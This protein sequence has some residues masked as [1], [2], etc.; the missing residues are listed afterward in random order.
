MNFEFFVYVDKP[1]L[2]DLRLDRSPAAFAPGGPVA[3]RL[4]ARPIYAIVGDTLFVHGGVLPAHVDQLER[5]DREARAWLAG[6]RPTADLPV[7]LS[8]P[9]SPVWTRRYGTPDADQAAV[10]ADADAVL[11]RL[12]LRRMVVAH[13]V[14]AGGVD[15]LCAGRVW[16][17]DTGL[18]HFYG[19]PLEILELRGDAA[20][21]LRAKLK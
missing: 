13:T 15:S 5:L 6:E 8:D 20:S 10:C 21:V 18:A 16:R 14:R 4:R 12:H 2:Q 1:L 11:S 9:E 19:G 7:A 17:I 3:R